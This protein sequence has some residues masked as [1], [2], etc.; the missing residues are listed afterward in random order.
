MLAISAFSCSGMG[1]ITSLLEVFNEQTGKGSWELRW[2]ARGQDTH[3]KAR[4]LHASSLPVSFCQ[5]FASQ[6][7]GD[8]WFQDG[9]VIYCPKCIWFLSHF[10]G[11]AVRRKHATAA[12]SRSIRGL[13]WHARWILVPLSPS[14]S[15]NPHV[16]A[17]S[18]KPSTMLGQR[19]S[20]Q[21]GLSVVVWAFF[22]FIDILH[23][24]LVYGFLFLWFPKEKKKSHEK[25]IET[26]YSRV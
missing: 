20:S 16:N 21:P 9:S 11:H 8:L 18:Q 5:K 6:C 13:H 12:C 10:R 22:L 25:F 19:V 26:A 7:L 3:P 15:E 17:Y 23:S 1:R 2:V 24:F 14:P 4:C